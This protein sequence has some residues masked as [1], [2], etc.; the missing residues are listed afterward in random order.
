M[1]DT[2]RDTTQRVARQAAE[3]VRQEADAYR[4]GEDLP[5][6]S[7]TALMATYAGLV[8]L[9]ALA[10]RRR[11]LPERLSWSDIALASAATHRLSRLIAKDSV[12]SPLRAPF[13]RF[14][15]TGGPSELKEEVRGT[16]AQK[17]VGELVS[18]PFCVGQWLATA[19]TFGLVLAPRATRMAAS[20]LTVVTAADFLQFARATAERRT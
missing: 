7:F 19:F 3:A 18:C 5:L 17:A 14:K 4:D 10:V 6:E 20:A 13:T 15:G 16:G 11:G 2:L 9:G 12:T 1:T 8:G